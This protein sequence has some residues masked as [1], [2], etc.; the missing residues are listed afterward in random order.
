MS[1]KTIIIL[2]V[3]LLIAAGVLAGVF[4]FRSSSGGPPPSPS[5]SPSNTAV[6]QSG[7]ENNAMED[8]ITILEENAEYYKKNGKVKNSEALSA[9]VSALASMNLT[10]E[11]NGRV[12]Q[13]LIS[14]PTTYLESYDALK[15]NN[16]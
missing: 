1:K 8:K 13:T 2:T 15:E 5:P 11:Q 10:A 6:K 12:R 7:A 4:V 14:L 3:V 9:A 16:K